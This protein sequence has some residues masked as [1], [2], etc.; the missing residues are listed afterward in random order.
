MKKCVKGSCPFWA[1][2]E[3]L[4][5]KLNMS[6]DNWNIKIHRSGKT[7]SYARLRQGN[8]AVLD[9]CSIKTSFYDAQLN[10]SS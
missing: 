4:S 6:N 2:I 9:E 1:G 3:R 10:E 7:S 8:Q 5:M